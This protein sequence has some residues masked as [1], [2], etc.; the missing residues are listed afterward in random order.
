MLKNEDFYVNVWIFRKYILYLHHL[1]LWFRNFH[2]TIRRGWLRPADNLLFLYQK[3]AMLH[4]PLFY[5]INL[6]NNTRT[7]RYLWISHFPPRRETHSPLKSCLT[8]MVLQIYLVAVVPYIERVGEKHKAG[9]LTLFHP[10]APSRQSNSGFLLVGI[11]ELTAAG[12]SEIHTPFP[13]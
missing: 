6:Y 13:F 11:M 10:Q 3:R 5:L 7:V 2:E 9:L 4:A 8:G 12:Q 1:I